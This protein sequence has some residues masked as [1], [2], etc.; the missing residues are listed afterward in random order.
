ME[1]RIGLFPTLSR[2]S[3]VLFFIIIVLNCILNPSYES[4]YLFIVFFLECISN[5]T[6]K[7]IS[8]F[9]YNLFNIKSLPILGIGARPPNANSCAFTLDN[10]ISKSYGMPSGHSQ[11][12]WTVATY[13]ICKIIQNFKNTKNTKNTQNTTV[14]DYIWLVVS[15]CIILSSVIYISYSRVYIE[16]CHTIQ[17]VIVGGFIGILFGYFIYYFENDAIHLLSKIW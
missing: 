17:Q 4:I 16:G 8:E 13:L 1:K 15:C 5:H 10:S 7:K 6:F 11:T 9:I 14:I 2:T 12:A 3:P